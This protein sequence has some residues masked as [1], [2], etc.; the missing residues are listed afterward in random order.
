MVPDFSSTDPTRLDLAAEKYADAIRFA[1]S[2]SIH[3]GEPHG[4]Q[5]KNDDRF[6]K[7]K[8]VDYSE[9]TWAL[10]D[11][12]YNPVSKRL[13]HVKL[14]E[15]PGADNITTSRSYS[16]RGTCDSFKQVY[17]NNHGS[18]WCL[19]PE[20]VGLNQYVITLSLGSHTRTVSIDGITG[21]VM[22]Q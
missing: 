11:D 18:A 12:I 5:Q 10:N 14:D 15:L 17:F 22:I 3:T 16:F 1:R 7:V 9:T 6:L 2:E 4:F 8:S 21:R 20:Q 13:Y 19:N